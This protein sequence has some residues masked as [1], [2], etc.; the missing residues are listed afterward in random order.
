MLALV[1]TNGLGRL[2][3]LQAIEP[4]ATKDARHGRFRDAGLARDLRARPALAPQ[5]FDP[6]DDLGWGRTPQVMRPRG[7]IFE[8]GHAFREE[9]RD[10]FA[11]RAR[12]DADGFTNGLRR[13]P[14][15]D[16]PPHHGLSTARRQRRILMNV[17]SV[18][19]RFAKASATS[20]CLGRS[21]MDNLLRLHS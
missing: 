21:R 7:T 1:A 6:C 12:A 3:C 11:H 10:P 2:E 18:P 9:P 5:P 20:A 16:N 4:E 8:G 17:H 15:L 14:A 19:P 13:L